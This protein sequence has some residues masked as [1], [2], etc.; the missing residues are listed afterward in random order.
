MNILYSACDWLTENIDSVCL[1]SFTTILRHYTQS[2]SWKGKDFGWTLLESISGEYHLLENDEKLPSIGLLIHSLRDYS[3]SDGFYQFLDQCFQQCYRKSVVYYDARVALKH[4]HSASELEGDGCDVDLL[5]VAIADQWPFLVQTGTE[6]VVMETTK[7][8]VQYLDLLM[9]AGRNH[10]QLSIIRDRIQRNTRYGD[11][12]TAL[13]RALGDGNSWN[14]QQLLHSPDDAADQE[15]VRTVTTERVPAHEVLLA[16]QLLLVEPPE[17]DED[18]K[19][20]CQ[21]SQES[22]REVVCE[23]TLGELMLCLSSQHADIRTQTLN[24]LREL[25]DKFKVSPPESM[26]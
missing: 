24:A 5:L 10:D 18:H 4:N 3:R 9:H 7:W 6:F 1:S 2:P 23:G 19:V 11:C 14:I 8:L 13:T 26:L 17:E 16:D 21:W 25:R 22:I 20:V 12:C 15:D